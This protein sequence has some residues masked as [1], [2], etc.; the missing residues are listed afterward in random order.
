MEESSINSRLSCGKPVTEKGAETVTTI[1]EAA[2]KIAATDGIENLTIG[3][4]SK[5]LFGYFVIYSAL[6]PI[7]RIATPSSTMSLRR[8]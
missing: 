4:V 8:N 2:I 5:R 1:L 7:V 3:K 6:K